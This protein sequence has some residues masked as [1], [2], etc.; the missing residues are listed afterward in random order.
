M[1]KQTFE[2]PRIEYSSELYYETMLCQ[3]PGAGENEEVID[4]PLD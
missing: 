3:S 1:K 4:E 2:E